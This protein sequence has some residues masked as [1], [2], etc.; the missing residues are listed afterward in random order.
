[1][2]SILVL[3]AG[4]EGKGFL[5]EVFSAAGWKVSLLDKD[6]LVIENLRKGSYTV[7]LFKVDGTYPAVVSGYEAY[8]CDPER[9]CRRA[10][11]DADVLAVCLY[12]EDIAEAAAYLAPC[13]EE[14]AAAG[15]KKLTIL[16]CTNINHLMGR[17]EEWFLAPMKSEKS[18]AWFRENVALR[19]TIVRRSVSAESNSSLRLEALTVANLLIQPP[20]HADL[21]GVEWME[22]MDDL[23]KMKDI[24]LYSLNAPHATCAYAGYLRGYRTICESEGDP[25]V[26][27]LMDEVLSEAVKGLSAEFGVPEGKIWDFSKM[28]APK[29]AL[30]DLI[31]RVGYDPLRKLAR[32]DRLTGN[33]LFCYNHGLPCGALV[34]SIANGLAYAEATD[35]AALKMQEIIRTKGLEAAITDICGLESGHPL[36]AEI[37]A[38]YRALPAEKRQAC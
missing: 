5:G 12:P 16:S 6:P 3:G 28:P 38:A 2:A 30:P 22:L 11:M 19:D 37:S 4:K 29:D 14:R 26:A 34:R 18:R 35:P 25:E 36:I 8:L 32:G 31:T 20:I 23:E 1:M 13:F 7:E 9:S 15:G 17:I 21:S 27:A 24:K 10:V 33:A